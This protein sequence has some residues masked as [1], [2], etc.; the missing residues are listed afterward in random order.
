MSKAQEDSG[1][2]DED[3]G[4][5]ADSQHSQDSPR[6][7]ANGDAA[8]GP[9]RADSQQLSISLGRRAKRKGAYTEEERRHRRRLANRCGFLVFLSANSP[10]WHVLVLPC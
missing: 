6:A 3:Y 1:Y 2:S 10:G 9:R 4:D 7:A 8:A 5:G